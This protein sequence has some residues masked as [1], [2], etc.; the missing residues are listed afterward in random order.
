MR[1]LLFVFLVASFSA[2]T[3]HAQR[4]L[5]EDDFENGLDKWQPAYS[6]FGYWQT[7][8]GRAQI[9]L[10]TTFMRNEITPKLIWQENWQHYQITFDY[11]VLQGSDKN[12]N[13]G[14]TDNYEWYE[15]HFINGNFYL[16]HVSDGNVVWS[17]VGH[18][19]LFTN[20]LYS[21]KIELDYD[22]ISI[23]VNGD[24]IVDTIDPT[25]PGSFGK[26]TLKA[27]TGVS[28]PTTVNFDNFK[29]AL[30][31]EPPPDEF[32]IFKQTDPAWSDLEYDHASTWSQNPT[33]G[34]WGCAL[35]SLAMI[36]DFYQISQLPDSSELT[37]LTLNDWL[38]SQPDG[39]LGEGL[40]NWIA[41][42]RLTKQM[43]DSLG[44][45][46]L[47][48]LRHSSDPLTIATTEISEGRPVIMQIP[49]H[50][51]AGY[52]VQDDDIKIADPAFNHTLFSQHQVNLVSTRSF[53]PSNTDLSYILV[54]HD[55]NLDL[56]FD[57]GINPAVFSDYL[58]ADFT[59]QTLANSLTIHEIAKP[60]SNDYPFTISQAEYGQF[61]LKFYLYDHNAEVKI[62]EYTGFAGPNPGKHILEYDKNDVLQSRVSRSLSFVDF[63]SILQNEYLADNV[64]PAVFFHLQRYLGYAIDAET[65]QQ[66]EYDRYT[67]LIRYYILLFED[68]ITAETQNSLLDYLA[69]LGLTLNTPA[70]PE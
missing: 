40:V 7:I 30:L 66:L 44:T 41:G 15:I 62:I 57:D 47:E 63:F 35:S 26:P 54:T 5:F 17:F 4:T 32:T 38:K 53:T 3:A 12:I 67:N 33:I 6:L 28:R 29:I 37:P 68:Q 23:S 65:N 19:T 58:E 59:P 49:G 56:Q 11:M 39:Y 64:S 50:F 51:L 55:H 8:N 2:R 1:L 14:F 9:T 46:K 13:F 27:T 43:S 34:R 31:E 16:S 42:T 45:P 48:Y 70:P 60:E 25:Y 18:K 22:R 20:T 69:E 24:R 52:Q 36:L 61:S 21:F 10:N